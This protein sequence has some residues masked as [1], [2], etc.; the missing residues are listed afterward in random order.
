M[1]VVLYEEFFDTDLLL[2]LYSHMFLKLV[3][4]PAL[5][6]N[7]IL[8]VIL[9][10]QRIHIAL[11]HR[12]HILYHVVYAVM[13]DFPAKLNLRLYFVA[14]CHSNVVHVVTETA[15]AHMGGL[16]HAD[17]RAHPASKLLLHRFGRPVPYNDLALNPHT[18]HDMPVLPV[19]VR[20]LVLIHEIHIY[21]VVRNLLIEL[22]VQMA[23]R[24][25]KLFQSEN[26]HLSR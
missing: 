4:I 25:P 9:L 6:N 20:G 15:H 26:P 17:R 1:I 7:L 8:A 5:V 10:N 18:A 16:D 2:R 13:V 22:R 21:T 24:F 14:F 12:I 3:E 19:A 11:R 23:E